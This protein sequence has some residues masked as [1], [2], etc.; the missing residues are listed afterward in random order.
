MDYGVT[1]GAA[2]V[3]P[4]SPGGK[5]VVVTKPPTTQTRYWWVNVKTGAMANVALSPGPDYKKFPTQIAAAEFAAA[6]KRELATVSIA[7]R[8]PVPVIPPVAARPPIPVVPP[9]V[10][11]PVPGLPPG[12]AIDLLQTYV[13]VG[14]LEIVTGIRPQSWTNYK[15]FASRASAQ[16]YVDD[17][18][19]QRQVTPDHSVPVVDIPS[20][21]IA[22][23][24]T[25]G[26]LVVPVKKELEPV[27]TASI[28][29]SISQDLLGVPIY[30][31]LAGGAL[32]LFLLLR[33][34]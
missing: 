10:K 3:E 4:R 33:K 15:T 7:A 9:L 21:K 27:S 29:P 30:V 13:N 19:L 25:K 34:K 28:M 18:R 8:P 12:D 5:P 32:V 26:G 11:P 17:Q 22:V 31:W 20:P 1:L 23:D 24:V 16:S 2:P 6:L 14:T